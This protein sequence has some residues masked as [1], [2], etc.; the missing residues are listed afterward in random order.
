[1]DEPRFVGRYVMDVTIPEGTVV[2]AGKDFLKIWRI[3]NDGNVSW[4]ENTVL[5]WVAGDKLSEDVAIVSPQAVPV[6][7]EMDFAVRMIAPEVPGRY[8][9]YWRLAHPD[10]NRFGQ[11]V[12]ADV[13]VVPPVPGQNPAANTTTTTTTTVPPAALNSVAVPPASSG[14]G[15][16][17][18]HAEPSAPAAASVV[19]SSNT[20]ASVPMETTTAPA[21]TAFEPTSSSASSPATSTIPTIGDAPASSM[22][23]D[24][25]TPISQPT[26]FPTAGAGS[27]SDPSFR[28]NEQL[29]E[30]LSMGFTNEV[31]IKQLLMVY[32]GDLDLVVQCLIQE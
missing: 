7:T 6:G 13:I 14:V 8:V 23:I 12:W 3:R 22:L 18:A 31:Q 17:S 19:D 21:T 29:R 5:C 11:R 20:T 15:V 9:S 27:S 30:V 4:P 1:M 28:Y 25:G 10:G 2:T 16:V 32:N 26:P 24:F